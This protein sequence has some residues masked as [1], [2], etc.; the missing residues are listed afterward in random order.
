MGSGKH[1]QGTV[2]QF[3]TTKAA[4]KKSQSENKAAIQK[5]ASKKWRFKQRLKH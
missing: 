4:R 2:P 5:A 1:I 3:A